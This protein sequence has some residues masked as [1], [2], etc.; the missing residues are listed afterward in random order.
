MLL[1]YV[2]ELLCLQLYTVGAR[3]FTKYQFLR[4]Y[5]IRRRKTGYL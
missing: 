3:L 1:T 5:L 2:Y 4:L